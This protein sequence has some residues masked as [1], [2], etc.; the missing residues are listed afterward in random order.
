MKRRLLNTG[1]VLWASVLMLSP[2]G[3]AAESE[4]EDGRKPPAKVYVPYKELK[5]VFETEEQGIFLPYTEFQR[6]W[7]AAQGLKRTEIPMLPIMLQTWLSRCLLL[8]S[9]GYDR[10]LLSKES[11]FLLCPLRDGR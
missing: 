3:R 6:L 11:T 4:S 9:S 8:I 10:R 7:R 2:G 5:G 1:V